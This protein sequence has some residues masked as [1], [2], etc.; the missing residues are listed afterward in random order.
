MLR[1]ASFHSWSSDFLEVF[2]LGL[3]DDLKH[4]FIFEYIGSTLLFICVY[5]CVCMCVRVCIHVCPGVCST[6]VLQ[7]TNMKVK[8]QFVEVNLLSPPWVPKMELG[9]SSSVASNFY[10]WAISL[11]LCYLFAYSLC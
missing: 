6:Q 2:E 7:H 5:E 1:I 8:R 3:T 10:P 9:L 11:S 4:K